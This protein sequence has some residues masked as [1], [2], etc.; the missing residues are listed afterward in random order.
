[1]TKVE[2]SKRAW[3]PQDAP[4]KYG[5]IF[6]RLLLS[7]GCHGQNSDRSEIS[8]EV[9]EIVERI[10]EI[11]ALMDEAV[12]YAG[13]RPVQYDNFIELKDKASAKELI[14][15]T[16]HPNGV[17]RCYSFWA[18]SYDRSIDLLTIV[19]RH[20]NDSDLVWSQYGRILFQQKVGDFFVDVVTPEMVDLNTY[21]LDSAQ[22]AKLDSI[23]IF[24]P[25]NLSARAAA[26]KRAGPR[27]RL[28]PGQGV[29]CP[30]P[31]FAGLR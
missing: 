3:N 18:L 16:H 19:V 22:L 30:V 23:L 4:M 2:Q 10:A 24:T 9:D 12:G 1:M 21:K 7:L 25:N 8:L 31:R 26:L 28:Y 13:E 15:L 29:H 5:T 6:I 27:E 17:V 14:S 11:N 20:L